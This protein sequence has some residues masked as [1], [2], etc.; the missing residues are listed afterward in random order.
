MIK[1]YEIIA[2]EIDL[3]AL[4]ECLIRIENRL[5]ELENQSNNTPT[6][7]SEELL[8][9]NEVAAYFKV[10][11]STVRNWTKQGILIKYGIGDRVYYKKSEIDAVLI[12]L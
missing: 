9:R 11:I 5:I 1:H 4:N 8:T 12:Q 10:N 6:P 3:N 7:F 2:C